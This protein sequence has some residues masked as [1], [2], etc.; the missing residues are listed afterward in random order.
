MKLALGTFARLGIE[1]RLGSNLGVGVLLALHHYTR[2]L[3]SGWCPIAP[4][5]F[6]A[7]Q[8]GDDGATEIELHVGPET[9]SRLESVAKMH[10]VPL[11][12]VLLHAVFVYLADL[13]ARRN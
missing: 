13:D 11:N 12:H 4:P 7:E 5:R 9:R 3:S 1:S 6:C 2:R 10:H 8:A